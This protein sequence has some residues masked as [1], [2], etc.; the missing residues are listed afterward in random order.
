MPKLLHPALVSWAGC[1]GLELCLGVGVDHRVVKR[2]SPQL[3]GRFP[4]PTLAR[5]GKYGPA[6]V[7]PKQGNGRCTPG[8]S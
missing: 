8:N 7:L 1:K 3:L 5:I 2:R 6:R 4:R